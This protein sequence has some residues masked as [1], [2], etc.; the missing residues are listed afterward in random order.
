MHANYLWQM[1]YTTVSFALNLGSCFPKKYFSQI[2]LQIGPAKDH[3]NWYEYIK[4]NI[5]L[6]QIIM[7]E[8]RQLFS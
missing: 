5:C 1:C 4:S 7:H 6:L 8:I 2:F 3:W